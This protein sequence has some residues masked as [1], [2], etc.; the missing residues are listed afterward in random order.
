MIVAR[1]HRTI[2]CSS[3]ESDGLSHH[4]NS[5]CKKNAPM[6]GISNFVTHLKWTSTF[7]WVCETPRTDTK[8]YVFERDWVAYS[9]YVNYSRLH[10]Q[11]KY[12]LGGVGWGWGGGGGNV[13]AFNEHQTFT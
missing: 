13:L 11:H 1:V 8:I 10:R 3:E 7:E 6:V 9:N 12:F 4:I 5:L 2:Y